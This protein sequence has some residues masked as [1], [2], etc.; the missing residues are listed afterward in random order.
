MDD[1]ATLFIQYNY[2]ETKDLCKHFLT[3][4]SAILVFSLTFSEKIVNFAQALRSTKV[5]LLAA[6]CCLI[7]SIIAC[8][9][10]LI[11]ISLAGG[12]A[13]YGADA[14]YLKLALTS[15]KAI[16]VAGGCFVLG[17]VLLILTAAVAVLK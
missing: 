15:Y 8:G 17:L 12:N 4:V 7:V 3:V 6:W 1:G 2:A 5:L 10:G 9:I 16:I 11:Y 14:S 13:V